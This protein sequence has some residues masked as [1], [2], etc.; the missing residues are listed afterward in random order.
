M[1]DINIYKPFP[2]GRFIL[3]L[4]TFLGPWVSQK[5]D[6]NG[7]FLKASFN[8][9]WAVGNAEGHGQCELHAAA[10]MVIPNLDERKTYK[11]ILV[12]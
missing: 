3:G 5:R 8:P 12:P 11:K 2:N 4:P 7:Q 6:N 9:F 10:F 1:G